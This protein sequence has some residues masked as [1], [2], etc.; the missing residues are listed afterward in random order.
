MGERMPR[1]ARLFLL[2]RR[3]WYFFILCL[4]LAL[5]AYA[6]LRLLQADPQN[7]IP[8]ILILAPWLATFGWAL[9]IY[10]TRGNDRRKTTIDLLLRHQMDR[11]IEEHK[12]R[13]LRVYPPFTTLDAAEAVRLQ[14]QY[15]GWKTHS[16]QAAEDEIPV[17]YSIVQFLNFYEFIAV[18]IRRERLDEG[19]AFD[20][21]RS[22]TKNMVQKFRPFIRLARQPGE[23]GNRPKPIATSS[24]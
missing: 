12:N 19:I 23:D 7:S 13:I 2:N 18:S 24:G 10:M 8:P 15:R 20:S 6:S 17:V 21:F 11:S 9:T 22:L 14:S 16:A 3:R 4:L 1:H 5:A